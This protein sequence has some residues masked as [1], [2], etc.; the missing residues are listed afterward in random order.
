MSRYAI[1]SFSPED[2][3]LLIGNQQFNSL[4][5]HTIDHL[6]HFQDCAF[7][8]SLD[9]SGVKVSQHAVQDSFNFVQTDVCNFSLSHEVKN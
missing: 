8:T 5:L 1:Y 6:Q 3:A 4:L 2:E 9:I 7:T